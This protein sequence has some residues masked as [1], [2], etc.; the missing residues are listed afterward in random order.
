MLARLVFV[1]LGCVFLGADLLHVR[2]MGAAVPSIAIVA[3]ASAVLALRDAIGAHDTVPARCGGTR[4]ALL[5]LV[6]CTIAGGI[7]STVPSMA[8][9]DSVGTHGP[10]PISD[11]VAPLVWAALFALCVR[12][13]HWPSPRRVAHVALASAIAWPVLHVTVVFSN[14]VFFGTREIVDLRVLQVYGSAVYGVALIGVTLG[15]VARHAQRSAI[16]LTPAIAS[17]APSRRPPGSTSRRAAP[18]R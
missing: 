5:A 15:I 2:E 8:I 4:M 9:V 10:H 11:R 13:L 1:Y 3:I 14:L 18:R 17:S 7:A 16:E 6:I 12:A